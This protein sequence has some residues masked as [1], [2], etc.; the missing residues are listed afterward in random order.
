MGPKPA[1]VPCP[2]VLWSQLLHPRA[3]GTP[4]ELPAAGTSALAGPRR[5]FRRVN[6][7]LG[8]A[9]FQRAAKWLCPTWVAGLPGRRGLWARP[10]PL[11]HLSSRRPAGVL[12]L[13][14]GKPVI[15]LTGGVRPPDRKSVLSG[16]RAVTLS[17]LR[18]GVLWA[19]GTN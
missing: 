5:C 3:R 15:S 4:A 11:A 8:L 12:G 10:G 6:V 13:L 18:R 1:H 9:L 19:D 16:P 7:F 2:G 17:V 14:L